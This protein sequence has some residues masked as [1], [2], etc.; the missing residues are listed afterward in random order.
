MRNPREIMAF[1][2]SLTAA[3]SPEGSAVVLD[4]ADDQV[5]L[6]GGASPT[7]P[8]LG[9][10][11][12]KPAADNATAQ[13]VTDGIWPGIAG[14]SITRNDELT[15]NGTDGTVKTAAPTAGTNCWIIGI[16]LESAS[17]GERVAMKLT[18]YM[19]QG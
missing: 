1:A 6:P 15:S 8:M 3:S 5:K 11:Y 18:G 7:T 10:L 9:L 2:S 12:E 16:A 19:K 17:S 4:T 13:V 14:A